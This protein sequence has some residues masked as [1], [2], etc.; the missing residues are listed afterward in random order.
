MAKIGVFDSGIGGAAIANAIRKARPQDE[1]VWVSD[2]E[3]LPYG[4]KTP[5]QLFSYIVPILDQLAKD[6]CDAIVIACNTA[7]TTLIGQLR[8]RCPVPLIG[9]EPMVKPAAAQTKT[10][11][12]AVCATPTTLASARYAWLKSEYAYDVTVLEPDCREWALMIERDQVNEERINAQ[13]DVVCREGADVI[14]WG[15]T[16]YHWIEE[17]VN[18]AAAGRARVLQPEPAIL[19]QLGVIL[20]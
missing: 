15:C 12:I 7:T 17:A 4:D 11:I 14:V 20:K 3:H 1:V 2:Q 13:I 16:H 8:A 6:D 9:I 5:A 18:R 19:K 10:G